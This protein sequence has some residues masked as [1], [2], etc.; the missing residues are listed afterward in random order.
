L[1]LEKIEK[2]HPELISIDQHTHIKSINQELLQKHFK[3]LFG[4]VL[5]KEL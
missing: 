3:K 5:R 2:I 4:D 1:D